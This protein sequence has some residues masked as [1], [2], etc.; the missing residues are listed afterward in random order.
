MEYTQLEL[1]FRSEVS[2]HPITGDKLYF[3]EDHHI[4]TYKDSDGKS[5]ILTSV[6]EFIS[7]FAPKFDTMLMAS[8]V[9]RKRGVDASVVIAEWEKK[10]IDACTMGTRIHKNQEML[11]A[12]QEPVYFW[13]DEKEKAIMGAGKQ[14]VTDILNNGWK[15]YKS[16]FPVFSVECGL[17]GTVDMIFQREDEW[18]IADWKTNKEI[19]DRSKYGNKMLPP[20]AHLDECELTKYTI[21][22]NTYLYL[23][24]KSGYI[25]DTDKTRMTIFHLTTDSYNAIAVKPLKELEDL[26]NHFKS[27]HD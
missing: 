14:A 10:K 9:A 18:M 16:E 5:S 2:T 24:K 26:I 27:K 20:I 7:T 17:A 3:D 22:L 11:L 8:R 23:L 6:S 13:I 4:Y 21:Q 15:L 19:N 12:G 1:E 25:K